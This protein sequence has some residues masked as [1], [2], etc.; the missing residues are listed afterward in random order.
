VPEPGALQQLQP[1][2]QQQQQQQQHGQQEAG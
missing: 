1:Q 2:G